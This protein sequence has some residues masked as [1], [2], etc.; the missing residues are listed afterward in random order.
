MDL[1]LSPCSGIPVPQQVGLNGEKVFFGGLTGRV[2]Q[3]NQDTLL[4][5]F[6][7]KAPGSSIVPTREDPVHPRRASKLPPAGLDC[8][9]NIWDPVAEGQKKQDYQ[10]PW[11][12]I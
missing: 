6:Q 5:S 2:L 3:F 9:G 12:G 7:L 10:V 4:F 1:P 11:H 8:S